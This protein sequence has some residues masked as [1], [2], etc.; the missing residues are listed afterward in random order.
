MW[1]AVCGGSVGVGFF[2]LS[3]DGGN[4]MRDNEGMMRENHYG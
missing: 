1:G 3:F 2:F 4:A